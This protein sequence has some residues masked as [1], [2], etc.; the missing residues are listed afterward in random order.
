MRLIFQFLSSFANS[1]S[2]LEMSDDEFEAYAGPNDSIGHESVQPGNGLPEVLLGLSI[3]PQPTVHFGDLPLGQSGV[4]LQFRIVAL[5][6]QEFLLELQR[7][8]QEI[9]G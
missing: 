6:V 7:I 3:P 8:L 4:E 1:P 5:L 9:V 2:K